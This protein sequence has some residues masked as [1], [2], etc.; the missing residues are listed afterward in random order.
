M[1][2]IV[3]LLSDNNTA[4]NNKIIEND[5]RCDVDSS[6]LI[7]YANIGSAKCY[8]AQIIARYSNK[9]LTIKQIENEKLYSSNIILKAADFTLYDSN[10]IAFFLSNSQLRREDDLFASSKVLQ[11]TNYAQNH[12]LP[13]VSGWVLPSLD[14]SVSK[15][16]KTNAKVSK[17]DVLFALRTLDNTLHIRTY[18]IGERITLADIS[19]F[20]TLLPL[21]EYVLDPHHR[22]QYIN[23]NRWFSTILNQPQVKCVVENFTF[24][25]KCNFNY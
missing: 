3:Y 13:A 16:M 6:K 7:L 11:W 25:T 14:I 8:L 4:N 12:I 15:E 17:E 21:Y 23:L 5:N 19:V 9:C 20:V 10:A 18:L 1:R 24:C 22:K 2:G